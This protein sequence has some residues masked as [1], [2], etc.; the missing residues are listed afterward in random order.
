MRQG[1]TDKLDLITRHN[2]AAISCCE[3][4]SRQVAD[5]IE[6]DALSNPLVWRP[7]LDVLTQAIGHRVVAFVAQDRKDRMQTEK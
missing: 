6:D 1:R 7:I 5:A 3:V 2:M 4:A